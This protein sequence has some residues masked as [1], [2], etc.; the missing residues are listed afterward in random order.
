MGIDSNVQ[1]IIRSIAENGI[2]A[3]RKW[4]LEA[5]EADTTQKNRPFVTRYKSILSSKGADMIEL[6][7][8]LRDTMPCEDVSVSFKE[9]GH[10]LGER[11]RQ[12]FR[13]ISKMAGGSRRL[14]E[15]QISYKN[16]T[17]LYGPPGTG[18]TTFGRHVAY[19]MGLPFCY[20]NFS[21]VVDSYMGATSRNLSQAFTYASSNPCVFMPDEVDAV[22]ANR[23]RTGGSGTEREMGRVTVTLMQEFDCLANDVVAIAA[24]NR[25]DLLDEAFVSR[26][27]LKCGM[28]PFDEE[29]RKAMAPKFPADTGMQPPGEEVDGIAR[30]AVNQR[31]TVGRLVRAIAEELAA[32]E[33]TMPGDG[34]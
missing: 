23:E 20:L 19:K 29:G 4:A 7:M 15:T 34:P 32:V 28:L 2:R 1:R 14:M 22:C 30:E 27:P 5:L 6:P 13:D 3:A 24:T 21:R 16:A 11:E 33:N 10:Y 25:P 12:A 8:N 17:L 31:E 26:C 18:K 9:S